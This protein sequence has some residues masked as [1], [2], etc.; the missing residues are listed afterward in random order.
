MAPSLT[1]SL[2]TVTEA[3]EG[4]ALV[5]E[6]GLTVELLGP[7]QVV[8]SN[9]LGPV[10]NHDATIPYLWAQPYGLQSM[11]TFGFCPFSE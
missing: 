3:P 9:L 8:R 5:T 6:A 1:E 2:L 7:G 11:L 10:G 4:R